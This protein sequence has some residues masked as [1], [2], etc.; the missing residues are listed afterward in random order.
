MDTLSPRQLVVLVLVL[1]FLLLPLACQARE[2]SARQASGLPDQGAPV[3][4]QTAGSAVD[5]VLLQR[6]SGTFDLVLYGVDVTHVLFALARDTRINMEIRGDLHGELTM[7]AFDQTLEEVL[8]SIALQVPMRYELRPDGITV[9]PDERVVKHH[10]VDYVSTVR[11]AQGRL[12]VST[13]VATTGSVQSAGSSDVGNDSTFQLR[14]HV[15]QDFWRTLESSLAMMLDDDAAGDLV[16]NAM[17]GVVSVRATHAQHQDIAQLLQQLV[18]SAQQQVVIEATILEIELNDGHRSGVDWR[19]V[20]THLSQ[21]V[22]ASQKLLSGDVSLPPFFSLQA[23]REGKT[24]SLEGMIRLLNTFGDT[25]VL[26][27]PRLMVLN[28]QSAVLKVV[29]EVVYFEIDREITDATP[30]TPRRVD[31]NTRIRTAPVGLVMVVT[32]QVGQDG[33]VSLNVRPTVSRILDFKPDPTARIFADGVDNLVPEIQVR[34]MESLLRIRSGDTAILGGL[35][36]SDR[37][38]RRQGVP[39]LS[40]LP[41]L[42]RLF[43]ARDE[44]HRKT[45]LVIFLKPVVVSGTEGSV[46]AMAGEQEI[47]SLWEE[48]PDIRL[49]PDGGR[50]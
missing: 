18:Q 29:D 5:I 37:R 33:V 13:T 47:H 24:S 49:A 39:R 17:T 23:A 43:S 34:E 28:N 14:M 6:A 44:S 40:R 38:G 50:L 22:G 2:S 1:R 4:V 45:E 27:S 26:S 20:G 25:Q 41:L 48:R 11:S 31:F 19:Y 30:N 12:D 16:V 36:Q 42:G 32:P 10:R 21:S 3:T 7:T 46:S 35:M 8:E 9:F 15:E